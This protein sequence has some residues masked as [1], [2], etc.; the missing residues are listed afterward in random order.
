MYGNGECLYVDGEHEIPPSWL[1]HRIVVG[2]QHDHLNTGRSC[3]G[4][5]GEF[6]RVYRA[7]G[8]CPRELTTI[9][10]VLMRYCAN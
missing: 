4:D 1:L 7:I 8:S 3:Y 5:A 2:A 9:F 10:F 6:N